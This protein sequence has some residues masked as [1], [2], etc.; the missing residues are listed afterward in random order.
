MLIKKGAESEL[1]AYALRGP[2][3]GGGK[4]KGLGKEKKRKESKT[5]RCAHGHVLMEAITLYTN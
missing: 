2:I 1:G 3:K 5:Q 4:G